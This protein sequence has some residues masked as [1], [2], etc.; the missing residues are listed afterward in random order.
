MQRVVHYLITGCYANRANCR[1]IYTFMHSSTAE[2]SVTVARP[3]DRL[4]RIIISISSSTITL[5]H[6]RPASQTIFF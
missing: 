5:E 1:C 4:L 3:V 6:K 2:L